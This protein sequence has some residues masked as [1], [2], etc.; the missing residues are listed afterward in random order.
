MYPI[1]ILSNTFSCQ[2]PQSFVFIFPLQLAFSYLA[3]LPLILPSSKKYQTDFSKMPSHVI[4]SPLK[5]F[6]MVPPSE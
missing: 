6:A 4:N 5:T 3:L 2:E 1:F